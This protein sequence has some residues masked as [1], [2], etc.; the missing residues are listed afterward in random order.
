MLVWVEPATYQKLR[1]LAMH[2]PI[3]ADL[4]LTNLGNIDTIAGRLLT[5]AIEAAAE[6]SGLN[7]IYRAAALPTTH[8]SVE[9]GEAAPRPPSAAES[10]S[11]AS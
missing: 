4:L 11:S 6:T 10:A 2:L 9:T 8:Y 5:E 1:H 3:A 7:A